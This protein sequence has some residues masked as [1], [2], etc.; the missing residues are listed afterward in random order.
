MRERLRQQK[1]IPEFI[2]NAF[3]DRAHVPVILS[4]VEES[5]NLPDAQ[6]SNRMRSDR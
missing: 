1:R 3:L 2:T 4:E 6:E 5:L